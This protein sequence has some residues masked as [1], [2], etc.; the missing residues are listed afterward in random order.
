MLLLLL[1]LVEW[2]GNWAEEDDQDEDEDGDTGVLSCLVEST[3]RH[4]GHGGGKGR[5]PRKDV[6][7][8]VAEISLDLLEH[9]KTK[10]LEK[11]SL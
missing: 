8:A 3:L 6:K 7:L 9:A 4:L 5:E 2:R 1:L 10:E 11:L